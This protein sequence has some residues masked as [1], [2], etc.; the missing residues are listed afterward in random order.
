[1]QR[2]LNEVVLQIVSAITSRLY[3]LVVLQIVS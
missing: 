3:L 1:M 2:E